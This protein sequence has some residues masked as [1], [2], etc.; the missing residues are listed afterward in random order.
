MLQ[1]YNVK[2]KKKTRPLLLQEDA[3]QTS[4]KKPHLLN[5]NKYTML[6]NIALL[7]EVQLPSMKGTINNLL[8]FQNNE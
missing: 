7:N 2:K 3:Q 1:A 4:V 6:P 8:S 5:S